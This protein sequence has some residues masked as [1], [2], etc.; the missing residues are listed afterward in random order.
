MLLLVCL[1]KIQVSELAKKL[2]GLL[3]IGMSRFLGTLKT[4]KAESFPI[5]A[6]PD[7]PLRGNKIDSLK[8]SIFTIPSFAIRAIVRLRT[9]TEI[10][11]SVVE[12]IAIFVVHN[13]CPSF[14]AKSQNKAMHIENSSSMI[15]DCIVV[16]G[17]RIAL[18]TPSKFRD[19]HQ[20]FGIDNCRLILCKGNIAVRFVTRLRNFVSSYT[21]GHWSTSNGLMTCGRNFLIIAC[22]FLGFSLPSLAQ[23]Q[24]IPFVKG[25]WLDQNGKPLAG[26]CIYTYMSGTSTPLATFTDYTA[27]QVNQNPIVLDSSGRPPFGTDIFLSGQA[28]RIRLV[29]A[30]GVNCASG[31]QIF[32]EDGINSSVTQ[33]LATNNVWTGLNTFQAATTFAGQA[34]F[35]LGLTSNGPSNLTLGGSLNGTFS[36]SPI[37]SGTPN[38]SNGFST[39]DITLSGQL[40]STLAMGAPPFVVASTTEVPN[41]NAGMLEGCTWEVPCPLGSTTPN[42]VAAT[43][44]NATTSFALNGST[45]ATGVQGSDTHLMSAGTV[46]GTSV[47]LCTDALGGATTVCPTSAQTQGLI[48]TSGI[49]TTPN[50][51]ELSCTMGPFNWAAAFTDSLYALTCTAV[52]PSG[53]GSHPSVTIYFTSKSPS[54]FG[55]QMNAGSA[56]AA[57]ANSVTEIDCI[58]SHP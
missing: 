2:F 4:S 51:G 55:L 32:Q 1:W 53:T 9:N 39:T 49:C 17:S 13:R 58:G 43:T 47:P 52:V 15:C 46:S 10:A 48:I 34:T 8:L 42:S 26:G 33:L 28:Y 12:R 30:G 38:F 57:G 37:F 5:P 14:F 20:I 7:S 19:Q 56:S 16:P 23:V 21:L 22:L 45:P 44:I 24:L 31:S 50:G 54:G 27:S 36:G 3:V 41:L 35:N 29:T 18:S 11:F 6:N 40:I 25:Q